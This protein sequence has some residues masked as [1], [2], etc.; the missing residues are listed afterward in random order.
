MAASGSGGT[1][2]ASASKGNRLALGS[3][4]TMVLSG[5]NTGDTLKRTAPNA[6]TAGKI[7]VLMGGRDIRDICAQRRFSMVGTMEEARFDG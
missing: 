3:E 7:N 2:L 4:A 1:L 5:L 6:M